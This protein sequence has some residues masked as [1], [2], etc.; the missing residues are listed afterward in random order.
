ML[1]PNAKGYCI[2]QNQNVIHKKNPQ[3]GDFLKQHQMQEVQQ[4]NK[5][6][7]TYKQRKLG[8]FR[9]ESLPNFL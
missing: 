6:T 2:P 3:K 1:K 8:S 4:K 9:T 5:K 7:K